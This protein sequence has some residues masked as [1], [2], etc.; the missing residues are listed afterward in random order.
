MRAWPASI[1]RSFA[2]LA[3]ARDGHRAVEVTGTVTPNDQP[4][5]LR[6]ETTGIGVAA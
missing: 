1:E 5:V 2:A 6:R 3:F 4:V